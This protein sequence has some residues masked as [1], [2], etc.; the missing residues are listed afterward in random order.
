MLLESS[1]F[2][3]NFV[4]VNGEFPAKERGYGLHKIQVHATHLMP[5]SYTH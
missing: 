4:G 3:P 2:M 5:L 1:D